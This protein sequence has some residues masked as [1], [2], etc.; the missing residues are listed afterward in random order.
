MNPTPQSAESLA[1]PSP[2]PIESARERSEGNG[3]IRARVLLVDD[4]ETTC[5]ALAAILENAGHD[6]DWET[7]PARAFARIAEEEFDVL[8]TDLSMEG[9]DGLEL[10]ARARD[11]N[12]NLPVIV[13]TGQAS[14][15]AAVGALRAG[16]FDF[17]Q[18]PV[19]EDLMLPAV[20]RAARMRALDREVRR[21]RRALNEAQRFGAMIGRSRPMEAMFTL[22]GRVAESDASVLITG[23]SGTGK[24]LVARSIHDRSRRASGP[25]VTVNC[26]AVPPT[27]IESELF[28]HVRG[29]FTDA[30]TSREGLFEQAQHG[31][32]FLDEVGELPIEMQ[33]K[34]LRALQERR[35]R[36]VGGSKEI[37]L[38]VRIITAT[39]RDLESAAAEGRFREDLL[40][41]IDVVR[42]DLPPLRAR[43][44]D[45]LLLAQHFIEE[46]TKSPGSRHTTPPTID[47]VVA[48][49]LLAYE[50]PGNVREL[51]NCIERAVALARGD[52]ITVEELPQKIRDF[53]AK[54]VVVSTEDP[55]QLMTLDELERR[56]ITRVLELLGGNKT[57]AARA[58]GVD[59][60]TL[61]RRLARHGLTG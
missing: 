13:F 42:V 60:R 10:C 7:R 20:M 16:A 47:P 54:H 21:L 18:K 38:D 25:F 33:P 15:D 27:L 4:D 34:L 11:L 6:V 59:R 52:T 41:R 55:R 48:E 24:E 49:R 29:A 50:W 1:V 35:V 30:K 56:Y 36:P 19:D 43:G 37:E 46:N 2:A 22:I 3:S 44:H 9:M 32:I 23:E 57:Q 12:P 51:Q 8:L 14:V 28:G 61:Y 31:T 5:E 45:I 39:N 26:A 58:L 53:Q 40:Y 17:L